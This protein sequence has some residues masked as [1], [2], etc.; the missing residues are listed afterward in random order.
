[1][2]IEPKIRAK[3][4]PAI[5]NISYGVPEWESPILFLEK[6]RTRKIRVSG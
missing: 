1:M 3:R 2:V 5:T 6:Q 4:K